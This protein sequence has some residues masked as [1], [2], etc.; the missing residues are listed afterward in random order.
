MNI[1][2]NKSKVLIIIIVFLLLVVGATFAYVIAQSNKSASSNANVTAKLLDDLQ[3]SVDKEINI[4]I[5]QFNLANGGSNVDDTAIASAK[6]RANSKTNTASR[7]YY[8]SFNIKS[9]NYIY[10]T[11]EQKPEIIL[12]IK[13][14]NGQDITSI[15]SLQYVTV[16]AADG[17]ITKG[18]DITT[19]TGLKEIVSNYEIRSNSSTNYTNQ[20]WTFKV[21]YINL[22]SDQGENEEH[23][24]NAEITIREYAVLADHIKAQYY[25]IQGTNNLYYHDSTLANGANDNSY[26]Y[27]GSSDT[28][29]NY[30]C[31]GYT[32][33]CN[34]STTYRIIGVFDDKVKLIANTSSYSFPW[35]SSNSNVWETSSI[36]K[37]L[38]GSSDS[39]IVGFK[40]WQNLIYN[41]AW[42]V[43]GKEYADVAPV[44]AQTCYNNE[45][46]N[47]KTNLIYNAKLGLPY[48]SEYAYAAL[49]SAWTTN[50]NNYSQ[51][52]D[53]LN[54]NWIFNSGYQ[55]IITPQASSGGLLIAS[56]GSIGSANTSLSA[57]IR[58]TF[59][60]N[61]NVKYKSGDGSVNSPY[62]I[63]LD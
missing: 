61:N 53:I 56:T 37:Y 11:T 55:W 36:N 32:D 10:T 23:T 24:L 34:A 43:S 27:A 18:F 26:R 1:Q 30:A 63:V 41:A 19:A 31:F 9:N 29:S 38:N 25:G 28:T 48:V 59:Y 13:D 2:K 54:N 3:F 20:D 47:P 44:T 33:S 16:T 15:N 6:L 49:P 5:N 21:T 14:P 22:D 50:I 46:K 45:I 39:V 52:K 12:T 17:T 57:Q 60:L 62:L 35:D 40:K 51:N 8:L 58:E 4:S 7:D 42:Q